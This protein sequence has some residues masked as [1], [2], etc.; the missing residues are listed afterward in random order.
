MQV[1]DSAPDCVVK[2]N[3]LFGYDLFRHGRPFSDRI[4]A[5]CRTGCKHQPLNLKAPHERN[6]L[7]ARAKRSFVAE[8][9]H[10]FRGSPRRR[11]WKPTPHLMEGN[12]RLAGRRPRS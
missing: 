7:L 8:C 4:R 11:S 12:R 9:H 2:L 3:L 5:V 1:R 6:K 10:S